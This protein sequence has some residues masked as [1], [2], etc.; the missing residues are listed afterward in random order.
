MK[1]TVLALALVGATLVPTGAHAD[2]N[3]G[4]IRWRS[5]WNLTGQTLAQADPKAGQFYLEAEFWQCNNDLPPDCWKVSALR[6]YG[7]LDLGYRSHAYRGRS[8]ISYGTIRWSD[9]TGK[10]HTMRCWKADRTVCGQPQ[11]V[12]HPQNVWSNL[13]WYTPTTFPQRGHF[14]FR[15]TACVGVWCGFGRTRSPDIV[16]YATHEQCYFDV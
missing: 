2:D 9:W 10:R 3:D 6:F 4:Q 16:C 15:A 14:T 1:A 13:R 11:R 8:A 12:P 7:Q 5:H